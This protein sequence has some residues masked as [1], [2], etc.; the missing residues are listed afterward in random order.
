MII[1]VDFGSQTANLIARVVKSFGVVEVKII[2]GS[3]SINEIRE[4][5]PKGIIFSGGPASVYEKGAPRVDHKIFDLG[6]PILGICYGWQLTSHLMQGE[7]RSGKKE[8]GPAKLKVLKA[9]PLL[10]DVEDQSTV[11]MSHGDTVTKLPKGFEIL[12]STEEVGAAVGGNKK[13]NIYGLQFHP[14]VEHTIFGGQVLK[15]F[16]EEVCG[17]VLNTKTKI[18]E[19]EIIDSIRRRVGD[20]KVICAVSGGVDSTVAAFLIGRAIGNNLYPVFVDSGFNRDGA[21]E[22]VQRIFKGILNIKPIIVKA[23][24]RFLKILAGVEDPEA[25]RKLVGK[26]YID[27]FTEVAKKIG[28][29]SFLAQG[30]IYSDVI[31]SKGSKRASNIKSHHNV[32]GLPED[33]KFS[34]LEPVR[35]LY[36]DEVRQLGLKLGIPHD[37]IFQQNYPGPGS[38]IRIMGA[39]TKKRLDQQ[40]IADKIVMEELQKAGW[41]DRVHESFAIMTGSFSTAVKGDARVFAEVVAVRVIE[42]KNIMTGDW[43]R[44]PHDLLQLI[45]TRI[46]NEVPDVSRVV[47]DI[48]T[49]PPATMEW[50]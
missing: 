47:Y 3:A 17:V 5:K 27:V 10:K 14:E 15:N 33:L 40:K 23:E 32:G 48:T 13:K 34:L 38:S 8:Y 26:T 43:S 35:Q 6:I 42:S 28:D 50:E 31:E 18:D 11:W 21:I 24:K 46:V 36:K 44:L 20:K 39:I 7:V 41:Y 49:K 1:I 19:R 45:S 12:A 9:S 4:L 2:D 37:V 30:T 22:N 25:K 16:V 29:V